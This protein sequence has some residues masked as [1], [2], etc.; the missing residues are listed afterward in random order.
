MHA[1]DTDSKHT[2]ECV[3]SP[4]YI[5]ECDEVEDEGSDISSISE[6]KSDDLLS[7]VASSDYGIE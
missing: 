1:W 5:S 4:E 3:F 6:K 7:R 2:W